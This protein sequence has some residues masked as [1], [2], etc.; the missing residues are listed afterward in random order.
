MN[1]LKRLKSIDI[2]SVTIMVTAIFSILA[3]IISIV[4]LIAL[5]IVSID[6]LG[7]M[8]ILAPTLIC[9]TI[10]VCVYRN[11]IQGVIYNLLSKKTSIMLNIE[12]DGTIS[13]I[14]T[15]STAIVISI[16]ATIMLLIELAVGYLLIQLILSSAIQTLM[17]AGQQTV[18]YSLYSILMIISQPTSIIS[19]VAGTFIIT[20]IYVLLG[21]YI[22]NFVASKGYGAELEI[23]ND[24]TLKSIDIKSFSTAIAAISL[25]LGLITGVV[26]AITSGDYFSIVIFTVMC[27]ILGYVAS[28]IISFLYNKLAPKIGEIK[29]K[30]VD[31]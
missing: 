25:I 3:I 31:D 23:A 26:N 10:I 14:S 4:G 30:L 1:S 21:T 2:S 28:A 29:F 16:I 27:F 15:T 17:M 18:A 24:S 19:A 22:Y 13:K 7:V 12:E 20:F 8:W 11:F 9:G 6:Y 5:G